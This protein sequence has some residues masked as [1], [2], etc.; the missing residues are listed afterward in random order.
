MRFDEHI[1]NVRKAA[2]ELLLRSEKRL[3]NAISTGFAP[4]GPDVGD[5]WED[6]RWE[7]EALYDV[8]DSGTFIGF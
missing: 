7:D 6:S 1:E 5:G 3:K 2:G 8:Y 4:A